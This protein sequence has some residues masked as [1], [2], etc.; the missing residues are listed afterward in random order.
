MANLQ[1]H[2]RRILILITL[3]VIG[4]LYWFNRYGGTAPGKY[5]ESL[6]P[7]SVPAPVIAGQSTRPLQVVGPNPATFKTFTLPA[8]GELVHEITC[9]DV[10]YTFLVYP[11]GDDYRYTPRAAVY[12]SAAGC[13]KD[14]KVVIKLSAAAISAPPGDYYYFA[15]DQG[16]SGAWYN[17]R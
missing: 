16:S 5:L 7:V 15:A 1:S 8:E 2:K 6:T 4:G 10:L 17:P 12:N 13:K 14:E 11:V 3:L 9:G